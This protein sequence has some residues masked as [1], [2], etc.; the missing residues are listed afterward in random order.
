MWRNANVIKVVT[1]M[2]LGIATAPLG[3]KTVIFV[4]VW[5]V[6]SDYDEIY[7]TSFMSVILSSSM[8]K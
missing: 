8:A 7:L 3:S 5:Y 6:I 1:S 2:G 4:P